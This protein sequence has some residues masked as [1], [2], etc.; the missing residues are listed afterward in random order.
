MLLGLSGNVPAGEKGNTK[1]IYNYRDDQITES[2]A[3]YKDC[4]YWQNCVLCKQLKSTGSPCQKIAY[5]Q[6][7]FEN[8]FK[9]CI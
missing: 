5:V 3:N 1:N 4:I 9:I 6:E 8:S 2:E 7:C